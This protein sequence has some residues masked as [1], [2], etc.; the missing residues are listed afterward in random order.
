MVIKSEGSNWMVSHLGNKVRK[1]EVGEGM[2]VLGRVGGRQQCREHTAGL[3]PHPLLHEWHTGH[4]A[5]LHNSFQQRHGA[6][7]IEGEV[8]AGT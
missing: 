6:L 7:Q 5:R 4:M 8:T 1:S 3:I 2:Q